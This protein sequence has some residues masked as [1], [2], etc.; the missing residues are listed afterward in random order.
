MFR[1]REVTDDATCYDLNSFSTFAFAEEFLRRAHVH[2]VAFG[3]GES[4]SLSRGLAC[5]GSGGKA[6]ANETI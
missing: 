6:A 2:F 4:S 5:F 1:I 3:A